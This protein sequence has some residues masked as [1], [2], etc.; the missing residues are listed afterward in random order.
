MGCKAALRQWG[1]LEACFC[2][3]YLPFLTAQLFGTLVMVLVM[4]T[5]DWKGRRVER[6]GEM[7][8]L[9]LLRWCLGDNLFSKL[10]A[11]CRQRGTSECQQG[12]QAMPQW[13]VSLM[14]LHHS[15]CGVGISPPVLL[16]P[17]H[18]LGQ[19]AVLP[20]LSGRQIP[21]RSNSLRCPSPWM[22][23]SPIKRCSSYTFSVH[24]P[25]VLSP[26]P[27]FLQA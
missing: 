27:G 24:A 1:C 6:F 2:P 12:F 13:W 10:H 20:W 11:K 22:R 18:K 7:M 9:N 17:V 14:L 3:L 25:L 4:K 21:R 19:N 15:H 5:T 16:W 8:S 26:S 23:A